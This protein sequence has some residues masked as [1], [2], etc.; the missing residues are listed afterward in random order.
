MSL[1]FLIEGQ[2]GASFE[3]YLGADT[4]FNIHLM[5]DKGIPVPITG[6]Q[7]YAKVQFFSGLDRSTT[8]TKEITVDP[9]SSL[10]AAGVGSFSVTDSEATLARGSYTAY[11][12]VEDQSSG[13][14]TVGSVTISAGG[15]NYTKNPTVVVNNTGTDG[16]G[17]A[18]TATVRGGATSPTVTNGGSGYTAAPDVTFNTPTGGVSATGYATLIS[19]AVATVVITSAGSG[20]SEAEPPVISFSNG[21]GSGAVATARLAGVITSITITNAGSGYRKAPVLALTNNVL[22]TTGAGGSL[23]AVVSRGVV[24]IS[25]VPS[26]ITIR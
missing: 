10:H 21:G 12:Y 14:G 22:D 19:G 6:P 25:S 26:T 20:Y 15:T 16:S 7:K 17:F 24:Q 4:T 13:G 23:T 5:T 11:A 2:E 3:A 1:R 18:A 8:L 9:D